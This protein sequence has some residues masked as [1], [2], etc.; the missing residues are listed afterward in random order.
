MILYWKI[1][2]YMRAIYYCYPI[3][4][5]L[6]NILINLIGSFYLYFCIRIFLLKA[7]FENCGLI[8][9]TLSDVTF[10]LSHQ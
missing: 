5:I 7:N 9:I 1:C 2:Y 3:S 4:V 6:Y 10:N 8:R